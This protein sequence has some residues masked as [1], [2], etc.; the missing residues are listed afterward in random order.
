MAD[1]IVIGSLY[2]YN[3]VTFAYQRTFHKVYAYWR[4]SDAVIAIASSYW[5]KFVLSYLLVWLIGTSQV[6]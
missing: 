4:S 6:S 3:A 5:T 2:G 1:E